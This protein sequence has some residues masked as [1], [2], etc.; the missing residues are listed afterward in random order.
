MSE[1]PKE[2]ILLRRRD[3]KIQQGRS[4]SVIRDDLGR[5]LFEVLREWHTLHPNPDTPTAEQCRR[6][7]RALARYEVEVG[8]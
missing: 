8:S 3:G 6:A 4:E 5:E 2:A 7:E 1:W